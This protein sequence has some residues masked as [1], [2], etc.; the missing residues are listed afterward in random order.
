MPPEGH[1]AEHTAEE[2]KTESGVGMTVAVLSRGRV[3]RS[4][5]QQ[6][7]PGSPWFWKSS[8]LHVTQSP[9]HWQ[10]PLPEIN[11]YNGT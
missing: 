3:L 9:L 4:I 8:G 10:L 6:V 11:G 2:I 5:S 1:G 7:T